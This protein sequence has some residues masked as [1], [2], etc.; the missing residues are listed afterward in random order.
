M[1]ESEDLEIKDLEFIF[2]DLCNPNFL[3]SSATD[4]LN[5][6]IKRYTWLIEK[7]FIEKRFDEY[8]SVKIFM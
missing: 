6:L 2:M 1:T 7:R 4:E 3:W 8:E 5:S